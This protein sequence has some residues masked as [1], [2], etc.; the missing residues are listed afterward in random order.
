MGI[1]D[2]QSGNSQGILIHILG[3]NPDCVKLLRLL[4]LLFNFGF[5]AIVLRS[6]NAP[7]YMPSELFGRLLNHLSV[8]YQ[9]QEN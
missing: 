1:F 8:L 4:K 9:M 7:S 2:Y 3:M 5:F 6:Y